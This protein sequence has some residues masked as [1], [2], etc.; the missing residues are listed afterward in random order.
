[1]SNPIFSYNADINKNAYLNWRTQ[2]GNTPE[3]L[4]VLADGFS[5]AA[6]MLLNS[7]IQ[8]NTLKEADTVIMPILYSIDQSIELYL[9]ATIKVLSKI[10]GTDEKVSTTHDILQLYDSLISKIEKKEVKKKGLQK[11][12]QELESYIHELYSYIKPKGVN[13]PKIDFARYPIDT[14]GTEH[15]YVAETENV[16]IDLEN[17]KNRF[18]DISESLDCIYSFYSEELDYMLQS[19]E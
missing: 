17:L 18:E 10:S 1:M 4:K 7:L 15:F 9:K 14:D 3:N 2:S 5:S 19:K 6:L 12:F 16:T 13:K 11:Q 8:D